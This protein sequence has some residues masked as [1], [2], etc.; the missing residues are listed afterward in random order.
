[1]FSDRPCIYHIYAIRIKNRN[2]LKQ[3][4]LKHGI[5]TLI[6][7]PIPLHMQDAFAYLGYKQ[8]DFP[9]SEVIADELLS[10]PMYPELTVNQIE[11]IAEKIKRFYN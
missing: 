7:Y 10:L 1:M 4:L 5:T 9:V 6:H 8:G 11:Y 3:Y 2:E